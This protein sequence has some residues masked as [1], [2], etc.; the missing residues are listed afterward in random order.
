MADLLTSEDYDEGDDIMEQGEEGDAFY[1]LESGV[2]EAYV[3]GE[4]DPVKKY[5][6]GL[7]SSV[8]NNFISSCLQQYH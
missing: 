2:A 1:I 4:E 7:A 8:H 5:L 6:A 3:D